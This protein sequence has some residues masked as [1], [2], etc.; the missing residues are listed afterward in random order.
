MKKQLRF[1]FLLAS[2]LAVALMQGASARTISTFDLGGA[3]A[4]VREAAPTTPRGAMVEL[5]MREATAHNGHVYMKF[6]VQGVNAANLNHPI[7][8]RTTWMLNN[9]GNARIEDEIDQVSATF[10]DNPNVMFDYFV[11]DP[12]NAKAN[13]NEA[14]MIYG[15]GPQ[16]APALAFDGNFAT[17]DLIIGPGN[18]TYL[19][20]NELRSLARNGNGPGSIPIENR[21]PLGEAFDLTFAPGS[22]LHLAIV[23]AQATGH[24]TVTVVTTLQHDFNTVGVS[25]DWVNHNYVFTPKEKNPMNI[26][27]AYDSDTTNPNNPLGSPHNGAANTQANPFAPQLLLVPEPTS[28]ALLGL[29]SLSLL[30][31]RRMD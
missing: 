28:M 17:D 4:E 30:V 6:G 10:N 11:L 2:G 21:I 15:P 7:T 26:D 5:G 23:A 18:L 22:A 3:D 29:C 27:T 25:P 8:V 24:K 19:G 31:R 20:S 14:T 16:A 13:W 12:N 1:T 9:L